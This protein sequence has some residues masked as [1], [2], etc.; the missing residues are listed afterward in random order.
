[1]VLESSPLGAATRPVSLVEAL[2]V[3]DPTMPTSLAEFDRIAGAPS[4]APDFLEWSARL[5]ADCFPARLTYYF[6]VARHGAASAR[7]AGD[8]LAAV[9]AALDVAVPRSLTDALRAHAADRTEVL[10]VVL[11]LDERPAHDR[12][13]K[14]YVIF[15]GA[16][17]DLV[18]LL[19]EAAGSAR[20]AALDP[21]R[22][23]ILG[24]DFDARGLVD[25]KLYYRLDAARL[26][27]IV[28]NAAD[29]RELLAHTH[30]LVLQRCVA[31][32]RTQLYLHSANASVFARW[33]AT[34]AGADPATARL[35]EIRAAVDATLRPARLEPRIVSFVLRDRRLRVDAGNVYYHLSAGGGRAR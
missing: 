7:A 3:A 32:E 18:D 35:M 1:M 5:E 10:Q 6:D 34:R 20:P 21:E 4:P 14:L 27:R 30:D 24:F 29:V 19:V 11:G 15:R 16:A 31:S 12:R 8:R 22:V 13:A 28:A 9:G 17:P 26:T 23:Y 33:L 2:L 25:A